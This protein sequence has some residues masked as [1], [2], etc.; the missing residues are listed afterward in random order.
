MRLESFF[1]LLNVFWSYKFFFLHFKANETFRLIDTVNEYAKEWLN[2]SSTLRAFLLQNS[3]EQN[4]K[5]I[6]QVTFLSYI[7]IFVS[8]INTVNDYIR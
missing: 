2:I 8:L 1:Q 6:K 4:L 5:S 3:T 7:I